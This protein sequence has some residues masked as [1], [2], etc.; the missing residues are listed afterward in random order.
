[1]TETSPA[2]SA[3][4]SEHLPPRARL[5]IGAVIVIVLLAFAVT[6]GIGMLRG[7]TGAEVVEPVS[8]ASSVPPPLAEAGLYVHVAGAVKEAG[9]YRLDAG[10]RVADAIAQAGG[11]ADD[12]DRDGVN[13][14]RPVADGEQI[15]VPVV[16]AET[17]EP[18]GAGDDGSASGGL[19]DLNTA[20]REQLDTLPRVGPAMADRIIEWRETN[21]RFTSVDDLQSVPGIGEKMLAALRDLV[22]V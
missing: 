8:T 14:A 13:L 20:T 1:M 19:I 9:L 11:F 22:R 17:S 5:G 6:V 3:A 7:A 10:D 15:V 16:G 2:P 12:A 4:A 18:G 21:G